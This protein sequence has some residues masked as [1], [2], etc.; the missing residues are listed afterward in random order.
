MSSTHPTP[1]APPEPSPAHPQRRAALKGGKI[2]GYVVYAYVIVTQIVLA[3]GFVLLLFGA[4]P[5]PPFVQWAY[6]SLDRAMEPFSGIFSPIE[7]GQ[8]G[9]DVEAVLDTSILFAML[10][11]GIAAWV[12]NMGIGW[13]SSQL[14]RLDRLDQQELSARRHQRWLDTQ[15]NPGQ[16]P[17]I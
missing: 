5:Q 17:S 6:R 4:N 8:T 11:Y 15:A 10:V 9:N 1:A 3:L 13:I 2:L 7:L 12:L 16:S 14:T